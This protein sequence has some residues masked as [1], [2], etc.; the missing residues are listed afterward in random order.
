[1]VSEASSTGELPKA[2]RDVVTDTTGELRGVEAVSSQDP[3][4]EKAT[5]TFGVAQ[6]ASS[7]PFEVEKGRLT[8]GS[9]SAA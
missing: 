5:G 6:R 4:L 8:C 2:F 3:L 1:M 7:L 9:P